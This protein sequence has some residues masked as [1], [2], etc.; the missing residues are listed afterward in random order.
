MA[1]RSLDIGEHGGRVAATVAQL[2]QR[3]GW[4]QRTLAERVTGEGRPMSASVL[5]KIEATTRRVDV[6]DLVALATALD[7]S[8]SALLGEAADAGET[9]APHPH[10]PIEAAV[11][12]DVEV[13]G[14]LDVIGGV[15]PTLAAVA[16]RLARELDFGG[17]E[18]GKTLH[19]L[20]KELR[21]TLAELA[22]LVPEEAP[23]DDDLGDLGAPD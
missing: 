22:G 7:V 15:A 5:G 19:S 17:G 9:E 13:L 12:E 16:Y 2:R 18:G 10:G 21:S 6:D 3:H 8:P 4:D 11:R 1:G 14:D 23:D 20:S